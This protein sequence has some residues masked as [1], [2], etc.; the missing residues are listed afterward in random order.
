MTD[1]ARSLAARVPEVD[2]LAAETLT[3]LLRQ[4]LRRGVDSGQIVCIDLEEIL[5]VAARHDERVAGAP[6]VD[7]HERD[8]A[9]VLGDDR[10]ALLARHD[11]AE[12][13]PVV[14]DEEARPRRPPQAS[15]VTR[16]LWRAR[17]IAFG[18][19]DL[20]LGFGASRAI[21]GP[22]APGGCCFET[23]PS[24]CRLRRSPGPDRRRGDQWRARAD[25]SR[26]R[27]RAR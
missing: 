18:V 22:A 1:L 3:H 26:R 15:S 20:S 16:E 2:P 27:R 13:A 14:H 17:R 23:C 6:R 24:A 9:L 21:T 5:G 7:V 4:T 25:P 8:R 11:G 19:L 10:R 12:H